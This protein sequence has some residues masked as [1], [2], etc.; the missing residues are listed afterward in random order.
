[1][2]AR[3]PALYFTSRSPGKVVLLGE[4]AVN[5]GQLAVAVSVGLHTTC[6]VA[7]SPD[8]NCTISSAG[9]RADYP[10]AD[11]IEFADRIDTALAT[12]EFTLIAD[13]TAR[14]FFASS[15]YIV[16]RLTRD[17]DLPAQHISF[18]SELP[19]GFGLGSGGAAHAAL[20]LAL[21]ETLRPSGGFASRA[22]VS[23]W[24]LLGD[25]VAHGGTASGLDTQT[26]L[27]GGAIEYRDG[28]QGRPLTVP[29]GL[30]LVIGNTGI[31]K[32][33]TGSVNAR[34][35]AWIEE[36]GTRVEIFRE[37]GRLALYTRTALTA[38]DWPALG[39]R[40]NEAHGLL[41]QIGASHPRLDALCQAAN[42]A[43][44]LGAKLTGAGGGGVMIALVDF[45]TEARVAAAIRAAG[46]T[47]LLAD[48][49]VPGAKVVTS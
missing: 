16:G 4:H 5:R 8:G 49:A 30:R 47:P 11:L 19:I 25:R 20:G 9:R 10:A 44:A 12:R 18:Q 43:G 2:T 45:G 34:V 42:G 13:A 38:G 41:R 6:Q 7:D 17:L 29:P 31:V 39:A 22:E 37:L 36:D 28:E 24:A 14:D 15:K 27:V 1:M 32:G 40:M 48:V 46:G 26:S 33:T 23:E 35:R 21:A 3:S